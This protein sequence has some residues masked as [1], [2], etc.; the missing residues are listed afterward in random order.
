MFRNYKNMAVVLLLLVFALGFGTCG[1]PSTSI[2]VFSHSSETPEDT[3]ITLDFSVAEDLENLSLKCELTMV[4]GNVAVRVVNADDAE[5]YRETFT[6]SKNFNIELTDIKKDTVY[7]IEVNIT[8]STS[9]KFKAISET[10]L[11]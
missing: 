2:K 3:D 4:S 1:S 10:E 8:Q 7:F 5:L 11:L 9:V 6:E